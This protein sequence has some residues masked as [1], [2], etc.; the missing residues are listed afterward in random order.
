MMSVRARRRGNRNSVKKKMGI[1]KV[2]NFVQRKTN[3]TRRFCMVLTRTVISR[4]FAKSLAVSAAPNLVWANN[5]HQ[6]S[7]TSNG[8]D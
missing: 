2:A 4:K 1:R 3:A 8:I 5:V 7:E 6:Y